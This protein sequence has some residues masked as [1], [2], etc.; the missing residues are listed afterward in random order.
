MPHSL[1]QGAIN[2]HDIRNTD[3]AIVDSFA[4]SVMWPNSFS[5]FVGIHK[6]SFSNYE[7][8]PFQLVVPTARNVLRKELENATVVAVTAGTT[9]IPRSPAEVG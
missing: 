6:N 5:E 8:C 9:L 3:V 7:L 1:I 4:V 2:R